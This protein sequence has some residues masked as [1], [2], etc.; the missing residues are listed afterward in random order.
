MTT[1]TAQ[2]VTYTMTYQYILIC[3]TW[4][5][6]DP[7]SCSRNQSVFCSII[8]ASPCRKENYP[9][10]QKKKKN[11]EDKLRRSYTPEK[12]LK[13]NENVPV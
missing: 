4:S 5:S 13:T 6:V 8:Q 12:I 7:Q 3:S 11:A 10:N 9:R 1:I 2:E